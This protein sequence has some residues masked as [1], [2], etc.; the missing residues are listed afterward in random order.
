MRILLFLIVLSAFTFACEKR[1][2]T[3]DASLFGNWE[4]DLVKYTFQS[5][6][7]FGKKT[8]IPDPFDTLQIDSSWGEFKVYNNE[9]LVFTFEGYRI[10]T[11]ETVDS[12]YLGPTWNYRIEGNLL[13]YQSSTNIGTLIKVP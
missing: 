1:E 11:G 5:N 13:R 8:L 4:D 7:E 12:T 3:E 6:M 9:I 2:V 10:K